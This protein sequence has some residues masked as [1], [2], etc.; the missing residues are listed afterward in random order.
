MSDPSTAEGKRIMS[1]GIELIAAEQGRART[2]EGYDAE[3]DRGKAHDLIRAARA[4][5]YEARI[6]TAA[7][8]AGMAYFPPSHPMTDEWPWANQYWKP[9]G[10]PIRDL[11]KAG[12]L[13][14]SAIDSLI[15][16][17]ES[18]DE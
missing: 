6:G 18:S 11:T 8:E 4:Y 10:D 1:T 16:A 7:R 15:A 9:T 12:G 14:A 5:A 17:K 13:I 2:E 3:H